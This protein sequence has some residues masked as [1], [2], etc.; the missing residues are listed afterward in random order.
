[1]NAAH[2][3]GV[4]GYYV[5]HHGAGHAQRFAAV[6]RRLPGCV[7]LGSGPRPESVPPDRWVPLP[8]DVDP[9]RPDPLDPTAGGALHWAPLRVDGLRSRSAA[10]AQW[11]E[12]ARP[13]AIV[14]DVSVE[15]ALLARLLSVPAVVVAQHGDRTD[16]PHTL[17]YRSAAAVVA[18]WTAGAAPTPPAAE[19]RVH[20]VGPISR[21]DDRM[22][23]GA[24]EEHPAA[25][26]AGAD[27]RRRALLMLGRG[28]IDLTTGDVEQ[29]IEATS[30]DWSW[31]IL[32]GFPEL[33]GRDAS[34]DELWDA[35]G[36][37][38]VVVGAASN[39]CVAEVA[40]ARRPLVAIPQARPF[41]EQ[42]EHAR[43]LQRLGLATVAETWPA[44][45]AWP[46]LL[47]A[48]LDGGERWASYH[49]GLGAQRLCEVIAQVAAS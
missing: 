36:A 42:H 16:P 39:N 17:A 37:A 10:F 31:D 8:L 23:D 29:A 44:P 12:T 40:A 18:L 27:G 49:D 26:S 13:A 33:G 32:G 20:H 2:R 22:I 9:G 46:G 43:A 19:G 30:A 5:H 6:A 48:A 1:M 34:G 7:G 38:D 28:G 24:R 4:V 11:V 14:V 47:D 21:F 3:D 35:L 41:D 45:D 25:R 15:I